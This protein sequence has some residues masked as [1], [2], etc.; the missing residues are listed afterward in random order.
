MT[1]SELLIEGVHFPQYALTGCVQEV[2]PLGKKNLFKRTVNG[3]LV[4]VGDAIDQKYGMIISCAE[5]SFP[6][7]NHFVQGNSV[8]VSS[9]IPL[10]QSLNE[11]KCLLS[12][13]A[14]LG[15][16]RVCDREGN[17]AEF[18]TSG[19]EI[20]A[21]NLTEGCVTYRPQ[22]IMRITHFSLIWDEWGEKS[23]WTLELDEI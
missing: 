20:I 11:G 14:V 2:F 19:Q 8:K 12:K 22:L 6:S 21:K 15:S 9:I 3:E 1:N 4:Y 13:S 23:R 7:L 5:D 10:T 16:I 17:I 18:S